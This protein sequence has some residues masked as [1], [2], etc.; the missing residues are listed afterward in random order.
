MKTF[1]Q[2]SVIG[3]I[4]KKVAEKG[5]LEVTDLYPIHIKQSS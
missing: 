3:A 5:A 2:L 4:S 1:I